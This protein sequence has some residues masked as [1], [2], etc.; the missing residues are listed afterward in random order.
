MLELLGG[1]YNKFAVDHSQRIE[2]MSPDGKLGVHIQNDGDVIIT[3]CRYVKDDP[4]ASFDSNLEF[5]TCSM[6]GGRSR[7]TLAA[8]RNLKIAID[9]D[10]KERPI[11]ERP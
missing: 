10:N 5:C 8:L 6:G 3:M 1:S 7:H 4:E 2:D 11:Q 9:M